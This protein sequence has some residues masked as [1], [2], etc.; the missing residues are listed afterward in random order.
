MQAKGMS[1]T[2]FNNC[3]DAYCTFTLCTNA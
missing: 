3:L 2:E 1:I